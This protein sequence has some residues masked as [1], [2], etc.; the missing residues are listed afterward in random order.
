[1]SKK[2]MKMKSKLA[3]FGLAVLMLGSAVPAYAQTETKEEQAIQLN[4]SE[5]KDLL[6]EYTE[7]LSQLEVEQSI[8]YDNESLIAPLSTSKN[9]TWTVPKKSRVSSAAFECSS[10]G[11]IRISAYTTS[12][13]DVKVGIIEPGPSYAFRYV[14]S[15]GGIT[16]N[17]ELT[18][19]GTYHISVYNENNVSITITGVYFY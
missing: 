16:H 8:V 15:N 19:D 7:Q 5:N 1:M 14:T 12:G 13:Y 3:V 10:G 17:F 4:A 11:V 9:F 2:H 18:L 6:Q